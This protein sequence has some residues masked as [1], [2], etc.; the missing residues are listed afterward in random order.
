MASTANVKDDKKSATKAI[1]RKIWANAPKA[2]M[3][4]AASAAVVSLAAAMLTKHTIDECGKKAVQD[5][6]QELEYTW[7]PFD[8]MLA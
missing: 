2:V 4:T 7:D 5:M 1:I 6:A 8:G 3:R